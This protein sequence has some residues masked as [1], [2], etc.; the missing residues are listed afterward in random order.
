MEE[1]KSTIDLSIV[2]EMAYTK[3]FNGFVDFP[4]DCLFNG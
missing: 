3:M 1:P 2:Y 4:L